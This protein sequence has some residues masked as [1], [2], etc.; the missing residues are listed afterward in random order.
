MEEIMISES[1]T[2]TEL[3]KK[4]PKFL[5]LLASE[6]QVIVEEAKSA[7]RQILHD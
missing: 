3:L 6:D 2:F 5:K 1:L 4:Y 7:G